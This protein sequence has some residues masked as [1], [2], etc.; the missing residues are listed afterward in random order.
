MLPSCNKNIGYIA[1]TNNP[2]IAAS[3]VLVL[4]FHWIIIIFCICCPHLSHWTWNL[5]ILQKLDGL[6]HIWTYTQKLKK[7]T[8]WK[9]SKTTRDMTLGL[10]FWTFDS[11][12][13]S[14]QNMYLIWYVNQ[15]VYYKDFI[16][17]WLMPRR[18]LPSQ[19]FPRKIYSNPSGIVWSSSLSNWQ[20]RIIHYSYHK[21]C[22]L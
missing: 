3:T 10:P 20:I 2:F 1:R 16:Y 22:P 7:T 14:F 12:A 13:A 6:L 21:G 15:G 5:R 17:R 8:G 4:C 18:K 9:Q 19:G 11:C